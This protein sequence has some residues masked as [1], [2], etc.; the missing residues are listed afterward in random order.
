VIYADI[1]SGLKTIITTMTNF[2]TNNTVIERWDQAIDYIQDNNVRYFCVL[3]LLGGDK[4]DRAAFHSLHMIWNILVLFFIAY[5]DSTIVTDKRSLLDEFY[6]TL[7]ANR[8]LNSTT[9]GAWV[10]RVRTFDEIVEIAGV[11]YAPVAI[12]VSAVEQI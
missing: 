2:D 11:V 1:E 5:D 10:S 9:P 6:T 12:V 4:D 7:K 8:T 3:N